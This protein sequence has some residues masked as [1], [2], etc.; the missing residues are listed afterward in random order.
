MGLILAWE[1]TL[2]CSFFV[3]S[4][5]LGGF[6]LVFLGAQSILQMIPKLLAVPDSFGAH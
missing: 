2:L 6:V 1:I 5:F 3:L 4:F